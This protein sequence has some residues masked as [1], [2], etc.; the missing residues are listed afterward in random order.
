MKARE[1]FF[2]YRV[3]QV[4]LTRC[5]RRTAREENLHAYYAALRDAVRSLADRLG[6]L[7]EDEEI[8]FETRDGDAI[9]TVARTGNE[10]ARLPERLLSPLSVPT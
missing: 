1:L 2:T 10:L 3:R 9:F 6:M 4:I 8:L 7:P 5:A